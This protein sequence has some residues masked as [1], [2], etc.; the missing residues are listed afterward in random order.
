MLEEILTNK[1]KQHILR[2]IFMMIMVVFMVLPVYRYTSETRIKYDEVEL[3]SGWKVKVHGTWY[4][5]VTL[6]GF[7]FDM[8][9][10][11]DT[12]TMELKLPDDKIISEALLT[13][14]SVH[15]VVD[16]YLDDKLFYTYGH[17]LYDKN[18]MLGYGMHY[19][20]LP[21][22]YAGKM[23]RIELIV[24]E[25]N[26]FDGLPKLTIVEGFNAMKETMAGMRINLLV[27]LFLIL[28]GV[29][30]M[31][32]S[33]FMLRKTNNFVQTYCIAMFS[34]LIGCWT[35]C[36]TDL[37]AFFVSDL[38]V[39]AYME[40]MSFYFL[41]I[42]ITYY[43]RSVIDEPTTPMVLKVYFWLLMGV[44]I[45]YVVT[46][47]VSQFLNIEHFPQFLSGCHIIIAFALILVLSLNLRGIRKKER[48]NNSIVI[49]FGLAAVSVAFE[50]VRYNFGKFLVGFSGNKYSST[51]SF[52]VLILVIALLVDYGQGVS[53]NFLKDA[54]Q[55]LLEQL[56]Y[57]DE[58][59]GLSNRRKCEET[60]Q[61]YMDSKTKYAVISL[62]MNF[63]KKVN[64]TLG[65]EMGD[66]LL[67]RFADMLTEVYSSYGTVGRM[68]GDEFIV[69]LPEVSY[70]ETEKL[71]AEMNF[72]MTNKNAEDSSITLS[73]AYGFAMSTEVEDDTDAHAA[74]RLADDRMY[75]HKRA[76]KMG[77]RD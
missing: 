59:T 45:A 49:G 39:K 15:S 24:T 44:E 14:Y 3:D 56:A 33:L 22:D 31:V 73:T 7:N 65:H 16:M 34:F 2:A 60:L 11:G 25:D 40:Y 38:Q 50:L 6:S 20:D 61:E 51:L 53:K 5:N 55:R 29:I 72:V 26:A 70:R 48:R 52:A 62:D 18:K 66:V 28:F 37:I 30:T 13:F 46:C 42:P 77:R 32:L 43:F 19:V 68:G 21:D 35:I 4:K 76:S 23:L 74:Y 54:K 57:M 9:N 36:N 17:D 1:T 58:L 71:I 69:I 75:E 47:Y 64:D 12:M 67:K 41:P 8:C 10:R 63:L 27:S